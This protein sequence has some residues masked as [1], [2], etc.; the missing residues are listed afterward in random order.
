MSR[1]LP[2]PSTSGSLQLIER[3]GVKAL[4]DK[5][6]NPIQLRGMSTAGLQWFP[7]IIN[8]N[9]FA[10][11]S[12]KWHTNVIRLAMYIG[13]N[14]YASNPAVKQKVIEGIELAI[15]HDM[16]VIVDWH[17]L[18]PGD[19]NAEIYSGAYDF[20]AE[21]SNLYPNDPHIIYELANEPNSNEPGVSND[22][23][24]WGAVKSYAEP[25]IQMLREKGNQN[26]V[27]VGSPNWSQRPD[28]A[29]DNPIADHHTL[30][31]V[32]FYTGTHLPNG[33]VMQNVQKAIEKGVAVF[34]SEW[35]TSK[36]DG[37][38]GNYFSEADQWLNFLDEHH[39]SWINWSLTNKN[40]SSAVFTPFIPGQQE[41]TDLDP[42]EN[43]DWSTNQLTPSG[44]YVRD[45]LQKTRVVE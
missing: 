24:G 6:G 42:G 10:A 34:A 11:L 43:L 8:Q 16:Y 27:I 3:N 36:A 31:S 1:S 35:G 12:Y 32:H 23:Q 38:Q 22:A 17:V 2:R 4:C 18:T 33:S 20:F 28:L 15:E 26:I 5:H 19:P 14:G 9:A 21:I 45:R 25:I 37:N 29:A 30:Y 40:E 7:E 39:I 13:E 41:A 44:Q